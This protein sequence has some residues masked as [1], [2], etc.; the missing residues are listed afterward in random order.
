LDNDESGQ[1]ASALLARKY[2]DKGYQTRIELLSGKD[3][4]KDLTAAIAEGKSPKR[5]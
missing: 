2:A 4:A 5:A 3:S 1:E